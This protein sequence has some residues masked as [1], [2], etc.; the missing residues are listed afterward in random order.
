MGNGCVK[1]Y[2]NG[3]STDFINA[4]QAFAVQCV[5]TTLA[6]FTI[7]ASGSYVTDEPK[8]NT[9][10]TAINS[11]LGT[12]K[13]YQLYDFSRDGGSTIHFGGSTLTKNANTCTTP[14]AG[15]KWCT[16]DKNQGSTYAHME[17]ALPAG[18]S[19]KCQLLHNEDDIVYKSGTS[20]QYQLV[21][22][23]DGGN[24]CQATGASTDFINAWQA[25]VVSCMA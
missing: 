24:N 7:A 23:T 12:T 22:A 8:V 4:W 20:A 25:F 9:A 3:A 11:A 1:I 2:N 21:M 17:F 15:L 10:V 16:Y 6:D 14:A 19:I 13:K 18:A 5:G